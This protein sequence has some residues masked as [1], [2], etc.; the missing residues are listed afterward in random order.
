MPCVFR[1]FLECAAY[2]CL[3]NFD[4]A[5]FEKS[6]RDSLKKLLAQ[7]SRSVEQ[8]KCIGVAVSGGADSLCLLN[9]LASGFEN[10]CDIS[11]K[12]VCITVDHSIRPNEEGASDADFVEKFCEKIGVPCV[13]KKIPEG[14]VFMEAARRGR[15]IEEAAR[16]LRYEA[17]EEEAAQTGAEFVCLAHNKNDALET[18]LMRF[19]QGS[20]AAGIS[21]VRGKYLRPLLQIEREEIERYLRE[22]KIAWC[23]DSTNADEKYLRNKIRLK[24]IPFLRENFAGFEN[25][26]MRGGEKVALQNA[27][28]KEI[29]SKCE[30]NFFQAEKPRTEISFDGEKFSSLPIAIRQELIYA[31]LV[32]LGVESRVP[33]GFVRTMSL[34]PEID[35]KK[36][37]FSDISART[38]KEKLFLKIG[39]KQAT[40]SGFFA[41]I[42][43]EGVFDFDGF[44]LEVRKVK[45]R[46]ECDSAEIFVCGKDSVRLEMTLPFVARSREIGDKVLSAE[47]LEKSVADIFSDWKIP[48]RGREKIPL[49]ECGFPAKIVAV[50]GCVLG[51]ENWIVAEKSVADF[52][53]N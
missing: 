11:K 41:I 50:L 46:A 8:V 43:E 48:E 14:A 3:M 44:S 39:E 21:Q 23:T 19:L 20:T 38:E 9:A 31:A 40:E 36:I 17:F 34:W 30:E 22:K 42:N 1:I 33:Y 2:I 12:L 45:N 32:R 13:V 24:L 35:F 53:G 10:S 7:C 25:A 4:V 29:A 37:S 26:V 47:G 52:D 5:A 16:A 51:Y 28:V 6:V 18:I 49:L 27:A 15:G